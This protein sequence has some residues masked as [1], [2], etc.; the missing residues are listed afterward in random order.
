MPSTT[1]VHQASASL[2]GRSAPATILGTAARLLPGI[3]L[4]GA[5]T[6]AA[7]LL[8]SWRP[9]CSAAHG[10]RRSSLRY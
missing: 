10:W 1:T 2:L 9:G 6:L 7:V 5:V 8:R 3:A 4:C